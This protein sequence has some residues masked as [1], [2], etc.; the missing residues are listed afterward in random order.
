MLILSND[1]H[2]NPGPFTNSYFTF[3]NWN[4]NSLAKDD[5]HRLNLI[6]ADNSIFNYD[7]ISLCETSLND[8]VV[9]PDPKNYLN[10]EYSFIP[11][12]KPD[13]SRH[14]GVGLYYK[15]TLAS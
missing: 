7:I 12:N 10:N 1:I 15:N 4:C 5:F 11:A 3:M 9:L 13:N 8:E 6:Q 2:Q 14:G